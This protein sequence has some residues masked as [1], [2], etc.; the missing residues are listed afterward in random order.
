MWSNVPPSKAVIASSVCIGKPIC[1]R[2]VRPSKT[3]SASS[4]RPGKQCGA[5]FRQV[6]M[7]VLVLFV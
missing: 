1:S 7:L 2:N 3:I 5:M 4:V 6:K